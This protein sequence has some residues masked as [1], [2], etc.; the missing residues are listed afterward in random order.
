MTDKPPPCPHCAA[1]KQLT[2]HWVK[3]AKHEQEEGRSYYRQLE[4]TRAEV[5]HLKRQLR[6]DENLAKQLSNSMNINA[7]LRK[8]LNGR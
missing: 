1:A 4:K 7:K 8:E 5:E 3:Q 6:V 2:A